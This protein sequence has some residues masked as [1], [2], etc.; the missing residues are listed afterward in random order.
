LGISSLKIRVERF[1]S[2]DVSKWDK[3]IDNPSDPNFWK[4]GVANLTFLEYIGDK[5]LVLDLGC[6]TGGSAFFLAEHG[7]AEWIIAVD[8]LKDMIKVAKKNAVKKGLEQKI[9]FLVC[10]GR[11]LPF[12]D[13]CFEAL[14]SRGDA[15]CFLVPLK[16][17]VQELK[18]MMK[19]KGVIILE[20]DNRL[21]WKPGTIISKGFQKRS[22]G[23]VV[24]VIETF[25]TKR[26]HRTLSYV[27][28]PNGRISKKVSNDSE[29]LEKGY[30]AWEYPLQK[31]RKETAEIRRGVATHWPTAKGLCTLFKKGG[32]AE[33]QA[34]GDGLLM[35]LL[36]DDNEAVIKMMKEEPEM[37]FEIERRLIQHV[38]PQ[39]A[40]TIILRATVS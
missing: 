18:R 11:Y 30:K 20:I 2:Y 5:K 13:S 28:D 10:D 6:G 32:F 35:K 31:I 19:P 26:N 23:K 1:P 8:L 16:R 29:F 27:L 36:L 12:R 17:T 15:F 33:V 21:D 39:K 25:T 22:D 34:M 40:P 24:Y 7:T 9:C 37:F 4:Y 3:K 14:M 38:N